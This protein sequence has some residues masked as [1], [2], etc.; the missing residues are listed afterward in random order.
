M[1]QLVVNH[2]GIILSEL[3]LLALC[4]SGQIAAFSE[5]LKLTVVWRRHVKDYVKRMP[6]HDTGRA[7]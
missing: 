3:L 5:S 7:E 1:T 6:I 4:V 2:D